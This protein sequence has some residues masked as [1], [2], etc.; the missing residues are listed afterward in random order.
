MP[1]ILNPLSLSVNFY[2]L[3]LGGDDTELYF[4]LMYNFFMMP[5]M[6]NLYFLLAEVMKWIWSRGLIISCNGQSRLSGPCQ[7]PGP[8]LGIMPDNLIWI[9]IILPRPE[10]FL[11]TE[12][13]NGLLCLYFI[14]FLLCKSWS[15]GRDIIVNMCVVCPLL[16]NC[17]PCHWST[18]K[19][20]HWQLWWDSYHLTEDIKL[21][22]KNKDLQEWDR[23]VV[24]FLQNL[25]GHGQ[26]LRPW[27]RT[28]FIADI[29]LILTYVLP[30]G[31]NLS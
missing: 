1:L 6:S 7:P 13:V 9:L 25:A 10:L 20:V 12:S 19:I 14:V 18:D 31:W 29:Y 15:A 5:N 24:S 22:S 28:V 27:F 17:R 3:A 8:G 4:Y 21:S 30:P 26:P 23:F 16:S 11:I 2:S